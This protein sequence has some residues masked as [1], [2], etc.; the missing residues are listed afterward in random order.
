MQ[1]RLSGDWVYPYAYL[2]GLDSGLD[3]VSLRSYLSHHNRCVLS[4]MHNSLLPPTSHTHAHTYP[5]QL[6]ATVTER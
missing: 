6:A 1:E 3:S 4:V 5:L 2:L